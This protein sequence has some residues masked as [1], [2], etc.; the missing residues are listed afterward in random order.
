MS[1]TVKATCVVR[2]RITCD[3]CW[4]EKTTMQQIEKQARD[5]AF[6]RIKRLFHDAGTDDKDLSCK[7]SGSSGMEFVSVDQIVIQAVSQD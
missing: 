3:S 7:R 6:G 1:K 2:L 4:S 5:D